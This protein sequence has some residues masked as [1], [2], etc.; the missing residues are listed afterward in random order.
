MK[1]IISHFRKVSTLVLLTVT[2][3]GGSLVTRA[4]GG[5]DPII[6]GNAQA[7]EVKYIGGREDEMV[8]K[9]VYKNIAGSRFNLKVFDADGNP[10]FQ[11]SFSDTNFDKTFKVT[12]IDGTG[13]LTF[14][15]RN[16]QDNSTQTFAISSNTRL[17]EDIEVKEVR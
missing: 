13:K 10:L 1:L 9:V 12:G 16:L 7:A 15:I 17:V 4:S 8:F 11:H 14:V 5:H 2:L 3:T 6:A